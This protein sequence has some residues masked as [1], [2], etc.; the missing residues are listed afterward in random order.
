MTERLSL[1]TLQSL[2]QEAL[3]PQSS[4]QAGAAQTA[5][6][7]LINGAGF[8]ARDRLQVHQNNI[9]LSLQDALVD[10]FPLAV[11]LV[12]EDFFRQAARHFVRQQKP[13]DPRLSEYGSLFIDFWRLCEQTSDYGFIADLMSLETGVEQVQEALV[14]P[15]LSPLTPEQWQGLAS[16]ADQLDQLRLHLTPA[17]MVITS[18]WPLLDLWQIAKGEKPQ[19]SLD[20]EAG[21]DDL[22]VS[23]DHSLDGAIIINK[24]T[25]T[26]AI[27]LTELQ[28]CD[29]LLLQAIA[30]VSEA[31]QAE[32][33][34]LIT[35]IQRLAALNLVTNSSF[36]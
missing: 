14:D 23:C 10:S 9:H 4:P 22:L 16:N 33:F 12:G 26:E 3:Q 18:L 19:D 31:S 2:M 25:G 35:A 13:V 5:I 24:I 30:K 29:G 27:F 1:S 15:H 7:A 32:E 34:D 20:I 6:A 36:E 28:A 17:M 11:S 8:D 21:G